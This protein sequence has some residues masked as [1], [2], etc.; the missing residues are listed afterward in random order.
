MTGI[1]DWDKTTLR[2][3]YEK[4]ASTRPEL[5][6]DVGLDQFDEVMAHAWINDAISRRLIHR[7]KGADGEERYAITRKGAARIDQ[8]PLDDELAGTHGRKPSE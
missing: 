4:G 5:V 7:V 1:D 6:E 8:P 3:L 2:V